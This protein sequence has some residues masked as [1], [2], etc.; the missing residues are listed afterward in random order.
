MIIYTNDLN[1]LPNKGF[2]VNKV[3]ALLL[4]FQ[5]VLPRPVLLIVYI[6]L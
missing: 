5:N 4:K 6:D 1:N 2:L 3:V